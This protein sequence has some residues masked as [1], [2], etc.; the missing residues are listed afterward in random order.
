MRAGKSADTRICAAERQSQQSAASLIDFRG[1]I[2]IMTRWRGI[3]VA[4]ARL[5]TA[6]L[7]VAEPAAR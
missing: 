6:G 4:L 3:L 5:L 7:V 1:L 2:V